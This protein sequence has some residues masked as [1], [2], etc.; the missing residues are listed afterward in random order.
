MKIFYLRHHQNKTGEGAGGKF[1]GPSLKTVLKNLDDLEDELP[2]SASS[3][4]DYFESINNLHIMCVEEKL[5]ENYQETIENFKQAFEV[6]HQEFGL[7]QTLK[8]HIIFDHYSD[9]FEMFGTNFKDTNG[10]HHE[11]LHH[12]LKEMERNRGLYMKKKQGSPVLQKKI[13]LIHCYKE[14]P[15]CWVYP[16]KIS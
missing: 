3:F 2:E 7:S 10:E 14:C 12:T 16:K 13:P 8:I 5:S 6:V 4:I 15:Q 11:A 1:N 9:Y